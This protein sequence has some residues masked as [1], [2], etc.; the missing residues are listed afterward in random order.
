MTISERDRPDEVGEL[1]RAIDYFRTSLIERGKLQADVDSRRDDERTRRTAL[2]AMIEN[3]R[4]EIRGALKQVAGHTEQMTFAANSLS[5]IARQS[6]RRAE[7]AAICTDEASQNVATVARA[8][9]ELFQSISEIETQ[10]GRARETVQDAADTTGR[11][12]RGDRW[13]GRKGDGD[14][15]DRRH[16]PVDRRADKSARAERDDRG[17]A[18][19]R[20]GPRLCGRRAGGEGARRP[21]RARHRTHLRTCRGHPARDIGAPFRRSARSRRR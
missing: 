15:R 1:A 11:T 12:S 16:D 3:F 4:S 5:E 20:R 21:D 8:S 6:T 19:R 17:G 14:R 9:E 7:D 18:R 10:V 2:D 13:P